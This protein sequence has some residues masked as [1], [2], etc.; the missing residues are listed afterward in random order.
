MFVEFTDSVGK[1]AINADAVDLVRREGKTTGIWIR[2]NLYYVNESYEKV[3]A[4]LK[5][6][7]AVE[8]AVESE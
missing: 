6:A 8:A 7:T 1:V 3:L 2:D 5:A 4:A